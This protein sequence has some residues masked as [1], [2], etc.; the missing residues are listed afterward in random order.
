MARLRSTLPANT[1]LPFQVT[2]TKNLF[3]RVRSHSTLTAGKQF[4]LMVAKGNT[5]AT[6]TI[7]VL[8]PL[9]L[10]S[11]LPGVVSLGIGNNFSVWYMLP[12]LPFDANGVLKLSTPTLASW[13][14]I[15][16]HFQAFYLTE[17]TPYPV[18]NV[19]TTSLK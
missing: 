6:Q 16:V 13:K 3:R 7:L 10:P 5:P 8:S 11:V 19:W 18:S 4:T 2:V 15:V 1:S 12:P 9:K 17:A 14:G